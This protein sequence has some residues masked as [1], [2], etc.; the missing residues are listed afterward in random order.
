MIDTYKGH[1][2]NGFEFATVTTEQG[3]ISSFQP[4][5]PFKAVD[6]NEYQSKITE[7]EA[8]IEALQAAVKALQG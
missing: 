6:Y 2:I 7:L 4:K 8:K 5:K 1:V 3:V